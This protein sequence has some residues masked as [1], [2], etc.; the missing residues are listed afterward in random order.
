MVA[1]CA[2]LGTFALGM[3]YG[4]NNVP[5]DFVTNGAYYAFQKLG[6]FY[7]GDAHLGAFPLS[8]LFVVLYGISFFTSQFSV[9]MISI[10]APLRMLLNETN[11]QFLPKA[12]FKKNKNDVLVNGYLLV[13][14]IVSILIAIPAAGIGSVNEIVKAIVKLISICMPFGFCWVFIAYI[15]MKKD[16]E[17]Y[18][19]EYNFIKNKSLAI[20][21]GLWCLILTVVSSIIGMY[22]QDPFQLMLNI[23]TPIFLFGLGILFLIISNAKNKKLNSK[24][25]K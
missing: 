1:V 24:V 5:Q 6:V 20:F 10:D 7:F 14:V 23:F 2:I 4:P 21:I 18:P 19:S 3:M 9:M 8:N 17:K 22:S 25:D 15:F 11:K 12:L 16:K 13:A